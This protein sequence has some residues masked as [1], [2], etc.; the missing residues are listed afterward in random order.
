MP[1]GR[2]RPG[3]RRWRRRR[4]SGT[5]RRW[6]TPGPPLNRRSPYLVG[7]LAAAGA[8]T[9]YGVAQLALAAS[10]MLAVLLLALFLAVGLDPAV[11]RLTA[12]RL[13]RWLAVTVVALLLLAAV[14]GFIAAAI[15]PLAAHTTTLIRQLPH[16]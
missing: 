1:A 5:G 16:H 11:Q 14:A 7:F 12:W 15:P 6:G 8:L 10:S 2:R 13:P 4:W 9:A 3:P